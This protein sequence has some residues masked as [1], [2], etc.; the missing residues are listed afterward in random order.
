[1][2]GSKG[3]RQPETRASSRGRCTEG[4]SQT[5]PRES[6]PAGLASYRSG[7]GG[8]LPSV[9][10]LLPEE[11][12]TGTATTDAQCLQL[13]RPLLPS[14]FV[15][16]NHSRLSRWCLLFCHAPCFRKEP[17]LPDS[18]TS[19]CIPFPEDR[20]KLDTSALG[21]IELQS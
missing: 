10:R 1:M 18:W 19:T 7:C 14:A 6:T 12:V 13:T 4:S 21:S 15:P 3:I 5:T 8:C 17:V 11:A 20:G 9:R 2:R 16:R